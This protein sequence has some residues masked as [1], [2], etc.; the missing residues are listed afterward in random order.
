MFCLFY[1]LSLFF[2]ADERALEV[3]GTSKQVGATMAQLLTAA[4]QGNDSYTGI[5]ARDTA[6]ALKV[7]ANAVR[8]VAAT[9]EDPNDQ[10]AI[11]KAA[12]SVMDKSVK[13]IEEAKRALDD[14]NDPENQQRL[15]HV[16][17]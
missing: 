9:S 12:Q 7:L 10:Q 2:K 4:A 5:A 1:E 6:R 15:A 11:L 14:P 8:G 16:C 17:P 3:G 13:L